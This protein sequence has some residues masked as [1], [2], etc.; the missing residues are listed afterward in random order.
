[1][2]DLKMTWQEVIYILNDLLLSGNVLVIPQ[3][4]NLILFFSLQRDH[5][6]R[7]GRQD[8]L[9]RGHHGNEA[10]SCHCFLRRHRRTRSY[11]CQYYRRA[12]MKLLFIFY[13]QYL[14]RIFSQVMSAI[15]GYAITV[16]PRVYTYYLR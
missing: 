14:F 9:H 8:V 5:R 15:F 1:M 3:S 4:N 6:L 13:I 12:L 7:A 16:I 10:R 11:A 2:K